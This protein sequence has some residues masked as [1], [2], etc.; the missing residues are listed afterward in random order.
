MV[1]QISISLKSYQTS[2]KV[3][4]DRT[5]GNTLVQY[6]WVLV[7]YVLEVRQTTGVLTGTIMFIHMVIS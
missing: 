4:L 2:K 3:D 6:Y 1:F 7:L 5:Y